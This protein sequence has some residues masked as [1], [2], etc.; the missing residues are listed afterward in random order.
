MLSVRFIRLK[1]G[2]DLIFEDGVNLLLCFKHLKTY[3]KV[4]FQRQLNIKF[5]LQYSYLIVIGCVVLLISSRIT[6][7]LCL[8]FTGIF[9]PLSEDALLVNVRETFIHE[10]LQFKKIW[11]VIFYS[12]N[13]FLNW[14]C[15]F[16][17]NKSNSK[18]KSI[19]L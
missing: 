3:C 18:F 6:M 15:T 14:Y 13:I 16:L 10:L 19:V 17:L 5:S 8:A 2:F 9:R 12:A 7:L 11:V 4:A 1:K